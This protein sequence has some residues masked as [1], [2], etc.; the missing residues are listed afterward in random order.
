M[1]G[2]PGSKGDLNFEH[3]GDRDSSNS[4]DAHA[5]TH[6]K[7][8]QSDSGL[9]DLVSSPGISHS[10][11]PHSPARWPRG[12]QKRPAT[13]ECTLCS[14]RFT[15]AHNLR[16]HLRTHTDG[17]LVGDPIDDDRSRFDSSDYESDDAGYVSGTETGFG[18]TNDQPQKSSFRVQ[19]SALDEDRL[20]LSSSKQNIRD[21]VPKA[22]SKPSS[23]TSHDRPSAIGT[24]MNVGHKLPIQKSLGLGTNRIEDRIDLKQLKQRDVTD[25]EGP[26]EEY[27]DTGDDNMSLRSFTESVFDIGS[28][29][30]SASSSY[31]NRN[32]MVTSFVDILLRDPNM[33]RLLAITTSEFGVS[34][35]RF[36]RNLSTI[37]KSYSR[38]LRR[39]V[40]ALYLS[41][42]VRDNYLTAVKVVR[43]S[44][45][46]ISNLIA[47]RYNERVPTA[48]HL[49]HRQVDII[50][51]H[52]DRLVQSENDQPSTNEESDGVEADFTTTDLKQFLVS[53]E[54]FWLLKRNIRSL[55]IP[56]EFLDCIYE[57]TRAF[58][59][60]LLTERRIRSIVHGLR[61]ALLFG[62]DIRSNLSMQVRLTAAELKTECTDIAQLDASI[63]LETYSEY[64][65]V[66]AIDHIDTTFTSHG[67]SVLRSAQMQEKVAYNRSSI[68]GS[69]GP[70]GRNARAPLPHEDILE[71]IV[72]KT[73]PSVLYVD[74]V[75][76][77][78]FMASSGAFLS[79][80]DA[81]HDLAYPTFFSEAKKF[82]R[83][84]IRSSQ[85][86]E[87]KL[88][89]EGLRLLPVLAEMESC[90]LNGDSR[91]H[92]S[93]DPSESRVAALD[94]MKLW[95]E[96]STAA[97]WDWWPLQPPK[98][99]RSQDNA[100]LSW[101]C[102]CLVIF[103]HLFLTFRSRCFC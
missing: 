51:R 25:R 26:I 23:Q 9:A 66:I 78:T 14:K 73:L 91:I 87:D 83:A 45:H 70:Q 97:E 53:G 16:S 90:R 98:R 2:L 39:S 3:P 38:H 35:G 31:G 43:S 77:W 86:S 30:S 64:I 82:V 54:P 85:G 60:L 5:N 72:A 13:F 80:A 95:V 63:F 55:V 62:R 76:H 61:H 8:R 46:Q 21:M 100:Q 37:L 79:F 50:S 44:R 84:T 36:T 7:S 68:Q 1:N 29:L 52:L 81:L 56:D 20:L 58:L 57:S 22:G 88:A 94:R 75:P 27:S 102:V 59:D 15:R 10:M 93:V 17:Q 92:F 42:D 34:S 49:Q 96:T 32:A 18:D 40:E 24:A 6:D 71:Q 28:V 67:R 65:S 48:Q 103:E 89:L 69:M 33:D 41:K 99:S 11:L 4:P 74:L 101:Q 12:H 47:S 19:R